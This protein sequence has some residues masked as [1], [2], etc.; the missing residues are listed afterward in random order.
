MMMKRTWAGGIALASAFLMVVGLF[1]ELA[2]LTPLWAYE[3]L[4]VVLFPV[5]V[6]CLGLWW[7]AREHDEDIPF[8]GY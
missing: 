3:I 6:I 1:L 7:M 4:L 5:F 2:G 8:I